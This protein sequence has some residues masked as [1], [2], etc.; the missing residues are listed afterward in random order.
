M[1]ELYLILDGQIEL[2]RY[3]RRDDGRGEPFTWTD[4]NGKTW[5][6][7]YPTQYVLQGEGYK[8]YIEPAITRLY[9]KGD[10]IETDTITHEVVGRDDA[11]VDEILT[12]EIQAVNNNKTY[13]LAEPYKREKWQL[14]H[15]ELSF[16]N[17]SWL[18]GQG[19]AL[20]QDQRDEWLF[21]QGLIARFNRLAEAE[22]D[23]IQEMRA[24][25][26]VERLALPVDWAVNHP[27]WP[28]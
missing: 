4:E 11:E 28:E 14:R 1:K 7:N 27:S 26:P 20:D 16:L 22:A 24:M 3:L 10:Y 2:A 12:A 15:M 19:P 6:D 5:T 8:L 23:I 9:T 13:L 21:I 18:A 17:Q 25:T